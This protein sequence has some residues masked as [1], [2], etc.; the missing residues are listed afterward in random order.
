MT[1]SLLP[2]PDPPR[3]APPAR[4]DGVDAPRDH[5]GY[6]LGVPSRGVRRG[7]SRSGSSR[8]SEDSVR[9]SSSRGR[10]D[11]APVERSRARDE[12]SGDRG[13][14]RHLAARDPRRDVLGRRT[15]GTRVPSA[16]SGC[17]S[18]R[19]SPRTLPS[20]PPCATWWRP[21]ADATS[22]TWTSTVGGA[23][24]SSGD[25]LK[26]DLFG[27]RGGGR[28]DRHDRQCAVPRHRRHGEEGAGFELQRS[29]SGQGVRARHDVQGALLRALR[30]RRDLPGEGGV[31]G[32]RRDPAGL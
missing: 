22:T 15:S 17:A 11:V 7:V 5:V 12:G 24:S 16:A 31:D 29:G 23:S 18:L 25:K 6:G 28:E 19:R 20:T 2:S 1:Y 30:E 32:S 21:P 14:H 9:T 10:R 26:G 3:R 27:R 13:R 8:T 4:A